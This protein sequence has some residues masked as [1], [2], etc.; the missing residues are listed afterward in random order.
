[1]ASRRLDR[2]SQAGIIPCLRGEVIVIRPDFLLAIASEEQLF[3][4][5]RYRLRYPSL[6]FYQSLKNSLLRRW[7][8]DGQQTL[9]NKTRLGECLLANDFAGMQALFTAFF[10]SIPHDWYRHDPI[11]QYE[12][13]YASVFYAY[14]ASLGL[15]LTPE[16][17]SNA[18]RLDMALSF[19]LETA[20]G[21]PPGC[22]PRG[23]QRGTTRR[24]SHSIATSCNDA[25]RRAGRALVVVAAITHGCASKKR[26]KSFYF[27]RLR[28]SGSGQLRFL[29]STGRSTCSSSR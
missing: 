22:V 8:S 28:D 6:E 1:V 13:Y 26:Q 12:G 21:L 20:V 19:N 7:T 16:E 25:G 11:A 14:F 5:F 18:G 3:G 10:A 4:E 9:A 29:G 15:D 17:A 23:V 2:T 27:R 24:N